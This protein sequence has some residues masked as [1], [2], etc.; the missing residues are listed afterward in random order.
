MGNAKGIFKW[1][2]QPG[3]E[4]PFTRLLAAWRLWLIGA[5]LGALL[6]GGIYG[7]FP[8]PYRAQA[9]VLVDNNLEA[10]WE[11]VPDR[12]LFYFLERETRKL[13]E[14]TWSDEV[15]G[16][17][18]EQFPDLTLAELRAGKLTLSQPSEGGWHFWAQDD[19]PQTAAGLANA[20]AYAFI[21]Y[22]YQA[23]A[24]SPELEAARAALSAELQASDE[25][26]PAKLAELTE[27]IAYWAE[28][29]PGIS[30]YVQLTLTEEAQPP[31]TR[32]V[33]LG[34]YLLV[35]SGAGAL[36]LAA[37]SVFIPPQER[38]KPDGG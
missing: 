35:G 22:S 7:L 37:L 12:R 25:P 14:I 30:P 27:E 15:L 11:A 3:P 4:D 38:G 29:T 9:T 8:P 20:W 1:L 2:L 34:M 5:L 24:S 17:I 10:A 33:E 32:S 28:H 6:A 31:A 13:E 16:Q 21:E 19:D 36:L 18:A 26:D 23:I